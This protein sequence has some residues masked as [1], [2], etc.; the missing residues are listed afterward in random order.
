MSYHR[1]CKKR[2]VTGVTSR[3]GNAHPSGA[4]KFTRFLLVRVA[5][6]PVFSVVLYILLFVLFAFF[7]LRFLMTSFVSST[8]RQVFNV[9]TIE[10]ELRVANRTTQ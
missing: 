7:Y 1:V 9:P 4:S 8:Y 3:A 2:N 6:S 10:K 5:Q